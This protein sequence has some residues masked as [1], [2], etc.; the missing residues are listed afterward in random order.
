MYAHLQQANGDTQSNTGTPQWAFIVRNWPGITLERFEYTGKLEFALLRGK[1][2]SCGT[3]CLL[4][5][6]LARTRCSAGSRAQTKHVLY[7]FWGVFFIT[8]EDVRLAAFG[9]TKLMNLGLMLHQ[10]LRFNAYK[11]RTIVP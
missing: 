5:H 4:G 10:G 3:K 8:A 11:E 1:Q 9:I 7:L 6:G 2:E